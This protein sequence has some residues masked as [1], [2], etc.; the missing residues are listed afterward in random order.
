V[1]LEEQE[2]QCTEMEGARTCLD[3]HQVLW[4]GD[5]NLNTTDDQIVA[6]GVLC[7]SGDFNFD[8]GAGIAYWHHIP[9]P[10]VKNLTFSTTLGQCTALSFESNHSWSFRKEVPVATFYFGVITAGPLVFTP[11]LTIYVGFDA[12]LGA[13]IT[14]GATQSN[15]LTLGVAYSHSDGWTPISNYTKDFHVDSRP[16]FY[17]RAS[18]T[19]YAELEFDFLLYGVA[20]TYTKP[21]AYLGL[22]MDPFGNPWLSIYAGISASAGLKAEIYGYGLEKGFDLFDYRTTLLECRGDKPPM[23]TSLTA[24]PMQVATGGTSTVTVI[25]SDPE[26]DPFTCSWSTDGGTLTSTTGC[27]SV[28][29]TAPGT[30]GT[31]TV[32]VSVADNKTEYGP[33]T[34][35]V[36]IAVL[37]SYTLTVQKSGKKDH[38]GSGTVTGAEINCGSIC[39]EKIASGRMVTLT[40]TP[41]KESVFRGWS[42]C[43]STYYCTVTMNQDRTVIANFDLRQYKL[44]IQEAG[45]GSGSVTFS[46]DGMYCVA[47]GPLQ[48]CFYSG[49]TVTLTATPDNGSVF[50]SW[51]GCDS[52]NGNTCTVP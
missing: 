20:G 42:G 5:D 50:T 38:M 40:A 46:P 13:G 23:I 1:T 9:Y 27:G 12:A 31:Y 19:G 24:S 52:T 39:S 26:N 43:D 4:D 28:T 6:N 10:T 30:L 47:P 48:H 49:T 21:K 41:D 8:L 25:A 16:V 3:L 34:S 22:D 18:A 37:P 32:S 2:I 35:V 45:I 29:W 36:S 51:T 15:M 33:S 14:Y 17:T 11:K 44:S 7:F